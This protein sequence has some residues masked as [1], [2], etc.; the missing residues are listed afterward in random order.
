VQY[1]LTLYALRRDE[2]AGLAAYQHDAYVKLYQDVLQGVAA[3]TGELDAA[4]CAGVARFMLAGIDGLL[5]QKLAKPNKARS[6]QGI[7]TLIAATQQFASGL[8]KPRRAG[9]NALY[10]I[11]PCGDNVR[12]KSLHTRRTR[13]QKNFVI[14]GFEQSQLRTSEPETISTFGCK[15]D[16]AGSHLG[17]GSSPG[18]QGRDRS[19]PRPP[20]SS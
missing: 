9:G 13:D 16:V 6:S 8:Y 11:K 14:A 10:E 18:L 15:L 2:A 7:E 17:L 1:E 3:R 4:R 19:I 12:L 20:G 5:L